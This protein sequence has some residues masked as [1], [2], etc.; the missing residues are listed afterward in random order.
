M[1]GSKTA[2]GLGLIAALVMTLPFGCGSSESAAPGGDVDGGGDA[3][4]GDHSLAFAPLSASVT[5]ARGR[6]TTVPLTL[7]RGA[8]QTGAVRVHLASTT[9]GLGAPD[10]TVDGVDAQIVLSATDDTP[11]GDTMVT[12]VATAIDGSGAAS[13]PLSM[14]ILARPGALDT[15]FGVDGTVL[16]A[17]PASC[18]TPVLE[19]IAVA[20]DDSLFVLVM[21]S[22]TSMAV[23]HLSPSGA[24]DKAYG[25]NGIATAPLTLLDHPQRLAVAG[26]KLLVTGGSAPTSG[27][28]MRFTSDGKPDPSTG[29]SN[30]AGYIGVIGGVTT[31][32]STGVVVASDGSMYPVWDERIDGTSGHRIASRKLTPT[33]AFDDGYAVFDASVE[34]IDG[35]TT[36]ILITDAGAAPGSILISSVD[37]L[38]GTFTL[39]L[40]NPTT[41]APDATFGAA[42]TFTVG[43]ANDLIAPPGVGV[44][45]LVELADHSVVTPINTKTGMILARRTIDGAL[46]STFGTSGNA[47]FAGLAAGGLAVANDQIVVATSSSSKKLG[48]L[49]TDRNGAADLSFG[50]GGKVEQAIGAG[51]AVN[52]RVVIQK[53][54]RIVVGFTSSTG[55]AGVA[56]F[57][58]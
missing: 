56:G 16:D 41:G 43:A 26:S 7:V 35:V 18:A 51:D 29:Q 11:L 54:G 24:V 27:M 39:S 57:S 13:K 19:D 6:S 10:V 53:S 52:S 17:I 21:C 33:G 5:V 37:T 58:P 31:I 8:A 50:T 42:K 49:R 36:G 48:L 3:S 34:S 45:G 15:T 12:F 23:A 55:S 20:A 2:T 25:T 22:D 9:A 4:T 40:H 1:R 32:G 38:T 30:G 46:V 44:L 47:T 28:M 14:T